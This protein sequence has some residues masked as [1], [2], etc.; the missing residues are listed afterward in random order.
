MTKEHNLNSNPSFCML[1]LLHTYVSPNG[2]VMPCCVGDMSKAPIGNINDVSDWNEIWNGE[3]YT[4]FRKNMVEGK[5]NPLCS[6]CYDTEKFS[7]TSA[8]TM[9]NAEYAKNYDEYIEHL[10]PTGELTTSKLKYLDFRFTN[11]CN[12]ACITCSH[13]L[14]SSWFDLM[15]NLDYPIEGPKF[16]EPQDKQLAYK[17]IDDNLDSVESIYFAGGEPLLSEYHWYTLDKLVDSGRAKDVVLRY[18]S[19]CSTL[20]YKDKDILDY[21]KQF[22]SVI[23]MASVDEINERFN[24]IRWP[25]N[26]ETISENLK[27]IRESFEQVNGVDITHML[28]YSPVISS[29]NAHRL[30]EMI[31]EIIDKKAYQYSML[32]HKQPIFEYFLFCNLLR[33]PNHLSIMNMPDEHWNMVEKSLDEFTEWYCDTIL[34]KAAYFES[35]RDMFLQGINKI[36]EMRKMEQKDMEF[37]DQ[38]LEDNLEYMKEYS[39]MDKARKTDFKQTFPELEWLYQ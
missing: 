21:W 3:N 29:L 10:L 35:K 37:F 8:R 18:S 15:K 31:Q 5:K 17:L 19:N 38:S 24:Y 6:F 28:V 12:Q 39:K 2:N 27:K 16:I 9:A 14:S 4:E 11:K 20:R 32:N 1:G 7:K 25:G 22:K 26:W 13:E 36:K 33:N 30:K 23:I 34:S